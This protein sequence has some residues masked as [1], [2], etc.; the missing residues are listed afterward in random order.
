MK[1]S[2]VN[3]Q[4]SNTIIVLKLKGEILPSPN[5]HAIFSL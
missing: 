2:W 3:I 1:V 4:I 5:K